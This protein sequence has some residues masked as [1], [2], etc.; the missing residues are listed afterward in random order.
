MP[1]IKTA[2][3]AFLRPQKEHSKLGFAIGVLFVS[4]FRFQVNSTLQ[5]PL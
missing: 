4:S 1:A 3:S 5:D 2:V